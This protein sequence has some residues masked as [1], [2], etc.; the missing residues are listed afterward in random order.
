MACPAGTGQSEREPLDGW[1]FQPLQAAGSEGEQPR[2]PPWCWLACSRRAWTP[3]TPG[4]LPRDR[5]QVLRIYR[6]AGVSMLH[7][8]GIST[9]VSILIR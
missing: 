7:V 1:Y 9:S 5:A 4:S 8:L 2:Q 3:M 6:N